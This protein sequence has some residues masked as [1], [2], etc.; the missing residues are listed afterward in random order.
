[1]RAG[2]HCDSDDD[3]GRN[4]AA[5]RQSRHLYDLRKLFRVLVT[6]I[7]MSAAGIS[8]RLLQRFEVAETDR[9]T[10]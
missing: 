4:E 1:L 6:V 9:T 3:Q 10:A 2:H 5:R 7:A 8:V